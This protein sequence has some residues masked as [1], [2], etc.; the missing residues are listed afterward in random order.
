[1]YKK[2]AQLMGN[3]F[4]ATYAVYLLMAHKY[5]TPVYMSSQRSELLINCMTDLSVDFVQLP[6]LVNEFRS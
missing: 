5:Q 3:A 2:C 4:N 6:G 1:M